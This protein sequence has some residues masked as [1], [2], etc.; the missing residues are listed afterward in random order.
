[1][2]IL[3]FS[4][5]LQVSKIQGHIRGENVQ[6][7]RLNMENRQHIVNF[8]GKVI[9]SQ[10]LQGKRPLNLDIIITHRT[11][12]SISIK[13]IRVN[14]KNNNPQSFN[15]VDTFARFLF[16]VTT[17]IGVHQPKYMFLFYKVVEIFH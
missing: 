3:K 14:A 13:T 2:E 4:M 6:S 12:S 10:V 1:M 8:N 5:R 16:G 9:P 15:I 7:E 17:W 11:T